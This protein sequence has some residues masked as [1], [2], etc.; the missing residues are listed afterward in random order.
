MSMRTAIFVSAALAL[1]AS[2]L[3]SA[4]SRIDR[5]FTATG[6]SCDQV[7]WSEEALAAYPNIAEACQEVVERD[8][9]YF[10]RFKGTVERTANR[11]REVTVDFEGGSVMTLTPPENLTLYMDGRRSSVASLRRGDQLNFFV[12]EDQL[13]AHFYESETPNA[14]AQVVPIRVT[15]L[16]LAAAQ[17]ASEQDTLP[18]TATILPFFGIAGLFL[19]LIGTGLT[20]HRH[21]SRKAHGQSR[22]KA[23]A[24]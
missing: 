15:T 20:A 16:K 23:A 1:S 22:H 17:P 24:P 11:G 6:T 18:S 2:A 8:G 10:V 4:Q 3:V 14:Q 21:H 9:K 7:T 13:A 5:T 19:A 12:P